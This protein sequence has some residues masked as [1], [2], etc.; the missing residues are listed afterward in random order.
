MTVLTRP[1]DTGG[2]DA[3]VVADPPV[4]DTG[5]PPGTPPPRPTRRRRQP[6][7]RNPWRRPWFLEGFTWLYL[8][9]SIFPIGIAVLFSFN[10]GKSQSVWQGFSTRWYWGDPVNSVFHNPLLRN[11]VEQTIRLALLTTVISV[12][13]GVAFA[14]GIHRWRSK[15][16]ATFNFVMVFTYVIPELIFGV[17]M[18]FL[19]TQFFK[20]I[21]LGT[22]AEVLGLVTWNFSWP[23]IIVLA[24]L[25]SI[26]GSYEEA[27]SDLGASRLQSIRRVLIPL[28]MPAI[29][30]SAVLVFASVVDDFVVVDLLSSTSNTQPMSVIIY[31]NTHGGNGGPA[32]NALATLMLIL[33]FVVAGLGVVAYRW[34]TRGE[35]GSSGHDAMTSIAGM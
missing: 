25:V 10:N 20:F 27:A 26:G 19:F 12:P 2:P 9:W 35:R 14:I 4:I 16:S 18:F 32:L 13:L 29:F 31:A 5:P 17:A 21:H 3:V 24:R 33:S 11:A 8:I 34:M 22:M 7:W 6:P 28:L 1:D 23:A 15:T 30:A